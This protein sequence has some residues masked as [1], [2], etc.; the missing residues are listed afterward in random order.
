M[1]GGA[2]MAFNPPPH[3][4]RRAAA[5]PFVGWLT[6]AFGVYIAVKLLRK[7]DVA[8]SGKPP[9]HASGEETSVRDALKFVLAMVFLPA[10]GGLA[11]WEGIHRGLLSLVGLGIAT[12]S[13]GFLAIPMAVSVVRWLL[14]RVHR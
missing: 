7:P 11:L 4:F 8:N 5:L 9:R 14:R 13:M 3:D 2:L 1:I 6:M 10:C 12:L